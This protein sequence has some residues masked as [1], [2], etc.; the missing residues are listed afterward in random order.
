MKHVTASACDGAEALLAR[1]PAA[2]QPQ[3]L[4]ARVG[5][6]SSDGAG[7]SHWS[8]GPVPRRCGCDGRGRNPTRPGHRCA[9]HV[10]TGGH[11]TGDRGLVV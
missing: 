8:V 2:C 4:T 10:F 7:E 11:G 3:C 1:L 9:R 5:P 6:T